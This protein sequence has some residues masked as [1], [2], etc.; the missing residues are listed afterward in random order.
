MGMRSHFLLTVT[1]IASE[2]ASELDRLDFVNILA[3][4]SRKLFSFTFHNE[5]IVLLN[6][7]V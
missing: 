5:R 2:L 6:R 7:V 1:G 3:A 4:K